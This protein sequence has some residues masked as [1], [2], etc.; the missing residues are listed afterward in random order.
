MNLSVKAYNIQ[1]ENKRSD[2]W[3]NATKKM[4]INRNKNAKVY[5]VKRREDLQISDEV[6]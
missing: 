3:L 4:S 1:A 2:Q 6:M 5:R